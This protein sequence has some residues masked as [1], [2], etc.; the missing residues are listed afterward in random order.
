[1]SKVVWREKLE[2]LK[3][4]RAEWVLTQLRAGASIKE[5]AASQAISRQSVDQWLNRYDDLWTEYHEFIEDERER[6]AQQRAEEIWERAL[7]NRSR[8]KTLPRRWT[9][10]Q[11]EQF[12]RDAAAE[13]GEPLSSLAFRDWLIPRDAPTYRGL[14]VR[15]GRSWSQVCERCGVVSVGGRGISRTVEECERVVLRLTDFLGRP[16]TIEEYER[17]KMPSDP[18]ASTVRERLGNG[19]WSGVTN[20]FLDHAVES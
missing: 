9:N 14:V 17:F 16:P 5:I 18:S 19:T 7:R 13:L 3:R 6:K 2:E 11:L 15:L 12:V 10:E 4:A 1:M 8:K 20:A